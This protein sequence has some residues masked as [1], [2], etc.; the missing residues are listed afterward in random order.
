MLQPKFFEGFGTH[1][2]VSV[3]R[4]YFGYTLGKLGV[5]L[6]Y[7]WAILGLYWSYTG[8]IWYLGYR[9]WFKKYTFLYIFC[10]FE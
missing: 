6:D 5:Y 8:G 3:L 9:N 7:T 10:V 2:I 1:F 4:I